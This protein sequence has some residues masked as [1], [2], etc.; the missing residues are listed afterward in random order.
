MTTLLVSEVFPPQNGGSGRWLFELYRRMPAGRAAVAAGAYPGCE[1]FD[2]KQPLPIERWPFSFTSWGFFSPACAWCYGQAYGQLLKQIKR[3]RPT[4]IH[5]GKVLPEGWLAWMLQLRTGLPYWIYVHGEELQFGTQSRQ[6]GWMMRRV[7]DAATG[8]IANSE[9]TA[10]LLR[11]NWRISENRLHTLNPGVDA[12]RF[13][14]APR[15]FAVRERLGWGER[16]VILTVGRLQK[17]KGHDMLIRAMSSIRQRVPNILY[18]IV[19]DGMERASLERLISECELTNNVELRGEPNDGELIEC[20]QQCDLFVLPNRT[21]D[22]DFEGFGMVLVEAQ[23]CGRPVLAGDSGGTRETMQVGTT[24][25]IVDCT[26]SEPLAE[27]IV[28]LLGDPAQ[29]ESM[30]HA[31]RELTLTRFD[32]PQLAVR[33]ASILGLSGGIRPVERFSE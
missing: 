13:R 27:A 1:A 25:R 2:L 33:A 26:R 8:V 30:G 7:F 21:V 23:A 9:N 3:T 12:E 28:D 15:S 14:P 16:P 18:S 31:A 19:G 29:R 5:C 11:R 10:E 17:R 24:G 32:W 22:G 4:A 20:Y 6:L